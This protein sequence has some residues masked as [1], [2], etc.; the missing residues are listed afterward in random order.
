MIREFR[1]NNFRSFG[2]EQVI[3]FEATKD[4]LGE[5]YQVIT[6]KDGTRLLRFAIVYGANASGKSNLLT[7]LEF[8]LSFV[9][10]SENE[11]MLKDEE[12]NVDP[13]RFSNDSN[14]SSFQ[15][16]F[17]VN[18][19]KFRYSLSVNEKCV[20][21]EKLEVYNTQK[22]TMVFERTLTEGIDTISFNASLK[23]STGIK[24]DFKRYTLPNTSIFNTLR[25]ISSSGINDLDSVFVYFNKKF[26]KSITSLQGNDKKK[27]FVI[28]L[29]KNADINIDDVIVEK[30]EIPSTVVKHIIED[31]DVP[32][33]VKKRLK[34]DPFQTKVLFEHSVHD[35]NGNVI[36]ASFEDSYES[37]GT[38]NTVGF[39]LALYD[40]LN[41]NIFLTDDEFECSFHP[42]VMKKLIFTFLNS[43]E[44]TSQLLITS[45][46]DPLMDEIDKGNLRPD[47]FWFT[48]KN[49]MGSTELYSLVEFNG[50]NSLKSIREAYRAGQLGALP[51]IEY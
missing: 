44:T 26:N 40:I 10:C 37:K 35:L 41:N 14:D 46:Y 11:E 20:T 49:V 23:V 8:V 39:G 30:K 25:H 42:E 28:N 21:F 36:H 32:Q 9:R 27:E 2:S 47:S 3:S 31:D 13:F 29:V 45:H 19:K 18:D 4:T 16:L 5:G 34:D 48:E 15:L 33:S 22:P 50:I 6:M 43:D 7:A 38:L 1:V 17:Y 51:H 24:N 12:L